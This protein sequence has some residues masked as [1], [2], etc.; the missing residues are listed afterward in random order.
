[1]FEYLQP[2]ESILDLGIGSGLSALPFAKAGMRIHG[3]DFSPAML[4]VCRA[5]G[6]ATELKQH[7]LLEI[8]WPYP[9]SQF[10]HIIC[11]GVLH[12]IS[13]LEVIFSEAKR[14]A[15]DNAIFAFTT[16][17]PL[18]DN[19]EQ[20]SYDQQTVGDFSIFAHHSKY[21]QGLLKH[22]QF[23]QLKHLKCFIGADIFNVYVA[24]KMSQ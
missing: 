7:D 18:N 19:T 24:R 8:P 6:I 23:K 10:D 20:H 22:L 13:D 2:G 14:V 1:M 5:K 12:F 17:A 16:K 21:V 4:E 9:A 15:Q 11:C 3:I